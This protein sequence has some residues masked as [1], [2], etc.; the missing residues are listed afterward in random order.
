MVGNQR[1]QQLI[2]GAS[3]SRQVAPVLPDK[4]TVRR[5]LDSN[6]YFSNVA[7]RGLT[8]LLNLFEPIS[9]RRIFQS[10]NLARFIVIQTAGLNLVFGL[11]VNKTCFNSFR[12]VVERCKE[13]I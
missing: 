6:F 11:T 13:I 1:T 5:R 8:V 2:L 3:L 7:D 9:A 4:H 12:R 10:P